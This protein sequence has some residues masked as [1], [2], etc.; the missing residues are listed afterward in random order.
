MDGRTI[1]GKTAV[2]LIISVFLAMFVFLFGTEYAVVG[3]NV[4]VAA[5][6]MLSRDLSVRPF[7]NLGSI[8]TFMVM[9]GVG[10]HL[11]NIDPYLG[12][13]VNFVVVFLIVFLS[14]QDLKSPMHFPMLLFYAT[15]VTMPV[16]VDELPDRILILAVSSIFIVGLNVI[17]N[18]GSRSRTSHLG[19][20]A[21]CDE[22]DSCIDAILAGE[23]PDNEKLD[24]I[25]SEMNRNM[26]DRLKSHFFST[27]ND[28]TVLDL[29]ISLADLGR[30]VCH[31]HWPSESLLGLKDVTATI[32]AHENGEVGA[33]VVGEKVERYIADN[34]E[35][36]GWIGL[37]LR[38]VADELRTLESGGDGKTYGRWRG[39]DIHTLVAV[40]REEGR[41]D[42]ARFT[43]AVRMGL[44]FT[45]VAF[46]WKYWEW[47]NAQVMLF[48]VIA[49][50][51]PFL[52]DS[53]K[54]SLMRLSGTILG[55]LV[56]VAAVILS[57]DNT[58]ALVSVGVIAAYAYVLL[59]GGRYDQK[60]FFYTL[61]VMIA[62]SL[63]ITSPES[64]L[65]SDRIVFPFASIV[66]AIIAN[67]VVLPYRIKDENMEL[68]ARSMR[69]SF[70]RIQNI[71]DILDG[72]PD[73]EED[74]ALTRKYGVK[75]APSLLVPDG[76][77]FK[78]YD[79]AS[80]IRKYIE[81]IG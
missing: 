4:A 15:M 51:V 30:I 81:S 65:V 11:A 3:V 54:L 21:M 17:M 68:A 77:G 78:T 75:K 48:T 8:M 64:A 5:L 58:I 25:A 14:M 7:S 19:I 27:P 40:L 9:M 6:I 33:D 38:D 31:G 66:V 76:N 59:D 63:T 26:Y 46:A 20:V 18:R 42:S 24:A 74:A 53:W 62:S 43:F 79:N 52:E 61:L 29:V 10:A 72:R 23:E 16:T 45:L 36:V 13:V 56:F 73:A 2:F 28:R 12:L 60:I 32:V 35:I 80:E 50:I 22:I 47:E 55:T 57:G 34:P 69:I 1:R 67:R 44:V 37:V 70:E 39:P 71:R 49:I 41:R